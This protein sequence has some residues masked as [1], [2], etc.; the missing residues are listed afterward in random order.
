MTVPAADIISLP[1]GQ[2][3]D[4]FTQLLI[5]R[6]GSLWQQRQSSAVIDG[7]GYEVGDFRVKVGELRQGIGGAQLVRGVVVE[8][9]HR[10]EDGGGE[11]IGQT[12]DMITAFR[13]ELGIDGAREY[14]GDEE[15]KVED[16]FEVVKLW[17]ELL[18]LKG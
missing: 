10:V 9:T 8:V 1:A 15:G 16:R 3:T 2:S 14:K 12:Q 4:D 5:S 7:L 11:D 6:L 18:V 13:D 17:S